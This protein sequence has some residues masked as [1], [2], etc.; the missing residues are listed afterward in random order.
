MKMKSENENEKATEN[1]H[2]MKNEC[3]RVERNVVAEIT[4][5]Q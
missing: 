5:H 1:E 3:R 2:R 4:E